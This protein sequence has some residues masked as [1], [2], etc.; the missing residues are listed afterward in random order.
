MFKK[1]SAFALCLC[2]ALTAALLFSCSPMDKDG[3]YDFGKE[4]SENAVLLGISEYK[5]IRGDFATDTEKAALVL[6]H[7]T[8]NKNLGLALNVGT[9]WLGENEMP[10]ENEI[11]I[12]ETNR[13]ESKEAVNG[14]GYNDYVIRFVNKKLVIVGGSDAATESA[15]KYFIENYIDIYAGTLSYPK[16][17]Y[18][19]TGSYMLGNVTVSGTPISEYQLYTEDPEIDLYEIQGELLDRVLGVKLEIADAVKNGKNYI[20]F[21]REGLIAREYGVELS[22][23]GDLTVYGSYGSFE[24]A[25]EYFLSAFFT[26]ISEKQGTDNIDITWHSNK[27][28]YEQSEKPYSKDALEELLKDVYNDKNS[29]IF[30]EALGGGQY[31]LGYALEGFKKETGKYPAMM[32]VDISSLGMN[33]SELGAAEWSEAICSLVSYAEKGG[34]IC[35]TAHFENPTGNWPSE[36][37]CYGELGGEDKWEELLTKGSGLNQKFTEELASY[38]AFL[39]DLSDNGV[40]VLWQP[41]P[42]MNTDTYWYGALQNGAVISEDYLKRLW[43]F[44]GDFMTASGVNNLLGVYSPSFVSEGGLPVNYGYPGDEY[45]S[46]VGIKTVISSRGELDGAVNAAAELGKT[47]KVTAITGISIKSGS[48][49]NATTRDEQKNVYSCSDLLD[50]IYSIRRSEA[51]IAYVST[52]GASASAQ[53]LGNGSVLSEDDLILTLDEISPRLYK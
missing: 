48:E 40:N 47:G 3:K 27:K 46:L 33:V 6:F 45:V 24:R 4:E 39:K 52:F 36:G 13:P 29:L 51:K 23:N 49:I 44:T 8:V 21:N 34:I 11:L 19:Y 7:G 5:I 17:G 42:E 32:T 35:L 16:K 22:D 30:G 9:D 38:A 31:T 37:K 41:F 12:G 26:E 25:K 10:P 2:L 43:I 15:V 28:L 53:W 1:F 18:K 20:R 14:L 50:D